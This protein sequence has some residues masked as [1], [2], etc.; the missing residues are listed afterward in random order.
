M[1]LEDLAKQNKNKNF[2]TLFALTIQLE[3]LIKKNLKISTYLY[4]HNIIIVSDEIHSDI[5][6]QKIPPLASHFTKIANQTITLNSA[7]KHLI[8]LV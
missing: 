4:K 3:S 5:T 2:S 7:G 8:L 1:D 6:F